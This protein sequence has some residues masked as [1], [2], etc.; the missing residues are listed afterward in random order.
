M[1]AVFVAYLFWLFIMYYVENFHN[2]N[3]SS[4]VLNISRNLV[5]N[6]KL[7]AQI[8]DVFAWFL[9][10]VHIYF[11]KQEE[12]KYFFQILHTVNREY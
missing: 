7:L 5:N 11:F 1:M 9:S 4:T 8:V 6:Q 2:H 3:L 12:N 10:L